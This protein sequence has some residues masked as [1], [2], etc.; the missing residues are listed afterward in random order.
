MGLPGRLNEFIYK[1]L[2][3]ASGSPKRKLIRYCCVEYSVSLG[4]TG[5]IGS[6]IA[7][8]QCA[9]KQELLKWDRPAASWRGGF[10]LLSN[11]PTLLFAVTLTIWV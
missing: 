10:C 9:L 5:P 4:R 3:I 8:G 7:Y 11:G 1:A 2:R 6:Q